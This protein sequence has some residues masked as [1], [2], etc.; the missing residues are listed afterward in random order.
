MGLPEK[1]RIVI[2]LFY[3]EDYSVNE[4]A[5]ILKLTQGN[6]KVRLSR[7]RMLLRNT[8]KEGWEDDE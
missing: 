8:L 6:V 5:D 1:Y 7:G 3:Y 4:I 2:H